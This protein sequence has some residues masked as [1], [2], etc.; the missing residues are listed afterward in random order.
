MVEYMNHVYKELI[1]QY[2]SWLDLKAF[3][4]SKEGGSLHI[5]DKSANLCIIRCKKNV[6]DMHM[7]HTKWFRSTVWDMERNRPVSVAPPSV[8]KYF[9]YKTCQ[10]L[11]DAGIFCQEFFDGFMINCFKYRGD[12]TLHITSRSKLDATGQFYS[13]KTFREL[14]L[15]AYDGKELDGPQMDGEIA[16]SYSFLVQHQEHR[17]V[18]PIVENGVRLIQQAFLMNDGMVHIQDQCSLFQLEHNIPL[19]HYDT[20]M[21]VDDWMN[22][23]FSDKTWEFQGIVLKD[24]HGNRWRFRNGAYQCIKSLRGNSA[25]HIDRF[26]QLCVKDLIKV[27]LEYY[28]TESFTF[29]CNNVFMNMI[30]QTTYN[31][32]VRMYITKTLQMS[33]VDTM[34]RRHLYCLHGHYMTNLR[35]QRRKITYVEV[36]NYFYSLPWQQV[37]YLLRNIQDSYFSQMS[38]AVNQ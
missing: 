1:D 13:S 38:E 4:L 25:H 12:D 18:T 24:P 3:L 2:P 21:T 33:E 28:P 11:S 26:A 14:F 16:R 8:T 35:P 15:E 17:V 29:L 32:Y 22:Q 19:I 5:S 30:H 31:Y 34:Y 9:P 36:A 20:N 10:E 37:A 23:F 7:N 6:T 27:Y